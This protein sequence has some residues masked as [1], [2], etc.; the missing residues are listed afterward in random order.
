VLAA[1]VLLGLIDEEGTGDGEPGT[2]V[3]LPF[4]DGDGEG[5]VLVFGSFVGLGVAEAGLLD[6]VGSLT[7]VLGVLPGVGDD[8]DVGADDGVDDGVVDGVVEGLG[9][10]FGTDVFL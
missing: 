6:P 1:G 8:V 5:T 7:P 4:P 3:L 10:A 9:V 2:S